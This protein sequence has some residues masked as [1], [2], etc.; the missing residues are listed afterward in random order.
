MTLIALIEVAEEHS[1]LFHK[2]D[3]TRILRRTLSARG[4]PA[5]TVSL[6]PPDTPSPMASSAL[7]V[8]LYGAPPAAIALADALGDWLAAHPEAPL[9]IAVGDATFAF[10]DPDM[11]CAFATWLMR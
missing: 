9:R 6:M 7:I 1:D 10:T 4:I 2:D 3:V 11:R 5:D 8:P